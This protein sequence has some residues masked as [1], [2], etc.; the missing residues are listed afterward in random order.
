MTF[1]STN[2]PLLD[3]LSLR[4]SRDAGGGE[5]PVCRTD[6]P[7]VARSSSVVATRPRVLDAALADHVNVACWLRDLP[8]L[9]ASAAE[10]LANSGVEEL[11]VTERAERLPLDR[12][13]RPFVGAAREWVRRDLERLVAV[14]ARLGA[15]RAL[16]LTFGSVAHDKCRKFHCDMLRYRLV[17]TYAGPGTEWVAD[18]D[19]DRDALARLIPCAETSNRLVVRDPGSIN[20]AHAGDVILMKGARRAGGAGAVHRSPPIESTGQRRLFLAVST[21]D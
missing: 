13:A 8:A 3:A 6:A 11:D 18:E 9:V 16:R 15:A 17:T 5:R 19:V 10:A 12:V 4:R 20:R 7:A 21:V 2:L 14:V 1:A